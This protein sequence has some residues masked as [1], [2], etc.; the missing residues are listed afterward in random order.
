MNSSASLSSFLEAKT[1]I[2]IGFVAENE[3]NWDY[4]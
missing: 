1:A 2:I 4:C 3:G